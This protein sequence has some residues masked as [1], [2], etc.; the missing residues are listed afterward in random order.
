M[1]CDMLGVVGS[2]LKMVK[3]KPTTPNTSQHVAT[4]GLNAHVTPNNVAICCIGM[5]QSFGRGLKQNL[6]KEKSLTDDRFT[7]EHNVKIYKL[8]IT[9]G[10]IY[11]VWFGERE[12]TEHG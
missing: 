12:L 5:L 1:L 6:Q 8:T 3:S 9:M 11:F 7:T 10:P 4:G 2:S